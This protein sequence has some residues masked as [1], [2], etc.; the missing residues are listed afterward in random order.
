[1][2]HIAAPSNTSSAPMM[3]SAIELEPVNASGAVPEPLDEVDELPE[4]VADDPL[5]DELVDVAAET[6][7][8]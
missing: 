1:V 5:V 6:S 2:A 8:G 7:A 3:L 4:L